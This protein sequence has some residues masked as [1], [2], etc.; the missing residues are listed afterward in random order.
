MPYQIQ[1]ERHGDGSIADH[2]VKL[3]VHDPDGELCHHYSSNVLVPAGSASLALPLALNDK[4]GQWK[5]T[6]QDV[7]SGHTATANFS[8]YSHVR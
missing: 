1:I 3:S 6:T 2:V 4:P 8:V 5:I 7:I